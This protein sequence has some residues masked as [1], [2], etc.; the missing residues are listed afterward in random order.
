[1]F[2]Y[3]VH[4]ILSTTTTRTK[5]EVPSQCPSDRPQ[6]W[7]WIPIVFHPS[8]AHHSRG[9]TSCPVITQGGLERELAPLRVFFIVASRG[10]NE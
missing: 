2:M 5:Y 6:R 1:M 3:V 9:P 8:F 4:L 10:V 7:R